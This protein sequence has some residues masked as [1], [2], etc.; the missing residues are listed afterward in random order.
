M[1]Q[2]HSQPTITKTK[3]NVG[4]KFTFVTINSLLVLCHG[5]AVTTA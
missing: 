2:N 1:G 5:V 4:E 3:C